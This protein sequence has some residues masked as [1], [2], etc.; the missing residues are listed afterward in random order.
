MC[1]RHPWP[2]LVLIPG[3]GASGTLNA[4]N[5]DREQAGGEQ[6]SVPAS[7]LASPLAGQCVLN[8]SRCVQSDLAEAHPQ[9]GLQPS[10]LAWPCWI[11][12]GAENRI[13]L[14]GLLFDA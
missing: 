2:P 7:P 8:W 5:L 4:G 6:S 14:G 11:L 1:S 10:V 9:G 13:E 3:H 12:G